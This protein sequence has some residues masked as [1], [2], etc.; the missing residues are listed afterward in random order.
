MRDVA[1]KFRLDWHTVKSLD[2]QYM[3]EQIKRAGMPGPKAIGINEITIRKVST[4]ASSAFWAPVSG[5]HDCVATV[6]R[7]AVGAG[8][9]GTLGVEAPPLVP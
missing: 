8:C 2:K 1:R 5:A 3:A 9:A 7:P 6:L 4:C